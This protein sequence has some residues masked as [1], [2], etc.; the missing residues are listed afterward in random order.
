MQEVF[1]ARLTFRDKQTLRITRKV[2]LALPNEPNVYL[3]GKLEDVQRDRSE[4][5][6][7][8]TA[9]SG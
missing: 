1:I 5:Q 8:A 3:K 9:M 2:G 6:A 4:L 7:F